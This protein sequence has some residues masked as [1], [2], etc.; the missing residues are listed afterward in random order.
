MPGYIIIIIIIIIIIVLLSSS[1]SSS[2][3]S[4]SASS[5][6]F[7][8]LS[9]AVI[10]IVIIIVSSLLSFVIFSHHHCHCHRHRHSSL[11]KHSVDS[12]FSGKRLGHF[13]YTIQTTKEQT[14]GPVVL[15]ERL[16]MSSGHNMCHCWGKINQATRNATLQGEAMIYH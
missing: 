12:T 4:S 15:P 2:L 1:S 8:H 9:F 16:I 6:F 10:I 13:K 11:V 3:S 14:F 7:C 5:L